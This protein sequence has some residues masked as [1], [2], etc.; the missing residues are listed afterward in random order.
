MSAVSLLAFAL[1]V[2]Q[3]VARV[4][5]ANERTPPSLFYFRPINQPSFIFA[6][7][8]VEIAD[9]LADDGSGTLTIR[10]GDDSVSIPVSIPP[11]YRFPGLATHADWF[12]VLLLKENE[13]F[14][15]VQARV[16]RVLGSTDARCVIVARLQRPGADPETFGKV[17]RSDWRFDFFELNPAGG[18]DRAPRLT[19][20]ESER[21]LARRQSAAR[22]A[23]EPI[24]QRHENE[25][26]PD[27]W[28]FQAATFVMP[29]GSAPKALT[30]RPSLQAVGWTLPVASISLVVS[31]LALAMAF[32]PSRRGSS[33]EP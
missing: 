26:T 3:L 17:F 10:Y 30:D 18:I 33:I 9:D 22:R 13:S 15:P 4:R 6:D 19:F 27:T 16:D 7:R 29:S 12:R 20:P 8:P 5:D 14:D 23:G 31:V 2:Q 21:S 24:P 11:R 32:A 28:Q 1:S 25:L